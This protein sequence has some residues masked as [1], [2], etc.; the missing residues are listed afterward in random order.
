MKLF[1]S[2]FS[3]AILRVIL[4]TLWLSPFALQAQTFSVSGR[5]V[6]DKNEPLNVVSINLK[7]S[8]TGTTTD[9]NG[10]FSLT[11]PDANTTLVFSYVG[12]L[13]QEFPI[14]QRSQIEVKLVKG[15]SELNEV[16]VVGYGTQKKTSLT[17]AVASLS[18]KELTDQSPAGDLRK[19]LQGMTPGL[20]ILD[21]GGQPGNNKIQMQIR[22]ISS[23][24]G[25]EPLVL[26]DGQVQ[27][28]NDID[29]N[30]VE[31]IS[32]LKDAASTAIYGSRGSNGIIIVTTKKGKKGPLKINYEGVYG[33]QRPSGLPEFT[34]QHLNFLCVI[35]SL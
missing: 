1:L 27:S 7:G 21:N 35:V 19:A 24:N 8:V 28:L 9:N 18:G 14:K 32:I 2:I 11:V 15:V 13:A 12:F 17:T 25:S 31:S 33:I 6:D 5:V 30:S 16:V 23:V 3:R 4:L 29:P 34:L 10:R 26:V 20:A 22:G